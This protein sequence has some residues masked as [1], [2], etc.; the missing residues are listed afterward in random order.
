MLTCGAENTESAQRESGWRKS[1]SPDWCSIR[2]GEPWEGF[3]K[4][5]CQSSQSRQ[6]KKIDQGEQTR[7]APAT[8]SSCRV[9]HIG[10]LLAPFSA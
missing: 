2:T 4:L 9:D 6:G 10:E 7:C 8:K 5:R 3:Q 1:C